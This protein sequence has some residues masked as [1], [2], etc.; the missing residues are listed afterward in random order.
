MMEIKVA[1]PGVDTLIRCELKFQHLVFDGLITRISSHRGL[2]KTSAELP[3]GKSISL[4]FME[5][6]LHAE[7]IRIY[8]EALEVAF[9]RPIDET[10][11]IWQHYHAQQ[12]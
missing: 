5:Y 7:I 2:V 11:L 10:K 3:I 12:A 6:I 9:E 4:F 1:W 8:L